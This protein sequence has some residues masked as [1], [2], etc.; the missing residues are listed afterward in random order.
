[1]VWRKPRVVETELCQSARPEVFNEHVGLRHESAEQVAPFG[2]LEIERDALFV[3]V[4]AEKVRAL[5]LNERRSP[6]ARVVS[7]SRLLDLDDARAH[8]GEQ[9]RA[10]RT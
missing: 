3:P 10:I 4:D 2:M 6:T 8:I 5:T 9:H 7:L 1:M